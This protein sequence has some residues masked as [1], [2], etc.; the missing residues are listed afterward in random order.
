MRSSEAL[1]DGSFLAVAQARDSARL[2]R[3]TRYRVREMHVV[4][5]FAEELNARVKYRSGP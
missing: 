4:L 5:S 1:A 2:P 3:R